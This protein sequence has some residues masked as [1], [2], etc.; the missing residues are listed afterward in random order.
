MPHK[1]FKK[2]AQTTSTKT[3]Y[4]VN[5]GK[6]VLVDHLVGEGAECERLKEMGF[7][8]SAKVVKLA[9]SGA[10]ICKVCNTRVVLSEGLAR[11]I[12]VRPCENE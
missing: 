3:L 8:E 12:V 11:S 2:S 1:T 9:E 10:L 4:D 7:C 5:D 6:E